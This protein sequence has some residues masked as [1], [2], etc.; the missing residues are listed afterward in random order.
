[1]RSVTFPLNF[2]GLYLKF[3]FVFKVHSIRNYAGTTRA[4]ICHLD[5][6]L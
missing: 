4:I 5:F 2:Q 1:M 3:Y 6:V